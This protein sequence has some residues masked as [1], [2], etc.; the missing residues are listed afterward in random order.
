MIEVE[1]VV[2]CA[3]GAILS[4]GIVNGAIPFD[5]VVPDNCKLALA[6][7]TSVNG[8]SQVTLGCGCGEAMT[9]VTAVCGAVHSVGGVCGDPS[10]TGLAIGFA[11]GLNFDFASPAK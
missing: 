4:S 1:S 9:G 6:G 10:K 11:D 3:S 2:T 8:A 5:S 7:V